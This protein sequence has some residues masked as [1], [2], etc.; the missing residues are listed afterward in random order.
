MFGIG[1]PELIVIMAIALLVVGPEKLP[2]LAKTL[3]RQ[4]LELKKA[5]NT[6][7]DGLH[8]EGRSIVNPADEARP[9]V[10]ELTAQSPLTQPGDQWVHDQA[11]GAAVTPAVFHP[12]PPCPPANAT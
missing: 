4:M 9:Q 2:E 7:Q 6:L 3:S 5:A 10:V 12:A 11:Q 1:L 8:E